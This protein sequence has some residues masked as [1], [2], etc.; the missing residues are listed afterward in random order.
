M[1]AKKEETGAGTVCHSLLVLTQS[2]L[3]TKFEVA[4]APWGTMVLT[5]VNENTL[6]ESLSSVLS[7]LSL[8]IFWNCGLVLY[9]LRETRGF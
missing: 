8:S 3:I 2:E 9:F 1:K 5:S 7:F 6:K 4:G